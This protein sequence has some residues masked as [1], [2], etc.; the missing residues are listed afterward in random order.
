[1]SSGAPSLFKALS[2]N[3]FELC[4]WQ[5]ANTWLPHFVF[6]CLHRRYFL[7]ILIYSHP[8]SKVATDATGQTVDP[9]A[10][11]ISGIS[12]CKRSRS[13]WNQTSELNLV[14]N[15]G[16]IGGPCKLL[17]Q[18]APAKYGTVQWWNWW[19]A[20]PWTLT[21]NTVVQNNARQ[22]AIVSRNPPLSLP[23]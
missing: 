23:G 12:T 17:S 1:M 20:T 6:T 10:Q 11:Q 18:V 15:R 5:P 9:K 4:L 14:S 3:M 19:G 2:K 8:F 7:F 16:T 21:S 13:S 22:H